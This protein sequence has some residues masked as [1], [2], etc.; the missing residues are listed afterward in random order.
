MPSTTSPRRT[1]RP[2]RENF[3]AP[4]RTNAHLAALLIGVPAVIG[5]AFQY[6]AIA[7]KAAKKKKEAGG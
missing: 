2:L 1:G 6:S 4:L 7:K 3:E 5:V